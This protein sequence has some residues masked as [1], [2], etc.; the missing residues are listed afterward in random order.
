MKKILVWI[1]LLAVLL[2]TPVFAETAG[3]TEN[4]DFTEISDKISYSEKYH[5]FVNNLTAFSPSRADGV[6]DM[7]NNAID[8]LETPVPVYLYFV[9]SSRSHPMQAQ[10][11]EDSPFYLHLCERLHTTANDHLKYTTFGEFC[12]Y[13]YATDHHWNHRGAYQGY[14]DIIRMILGE[15]EKVLVPAEEVTLPV[16]YNGALAKAAGKAASTE[17]FSLYRYNRLRTYICHIN[18]KRHRYDNIKSY[19][20]GRYSTEEFAN[21]YQLCY[22][23][24]YAKL[25]FET[26]QAGKPNLLVFTNSIG[27]G[28]KYLLP[29]HFNRIVC[30]DLRSYLRDMGEPLSLQK[31]VSEYRIGQILILG[32]SQFFIDAKDLVP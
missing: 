3:D 32:E 20:S 21:H 29:S 12:N 26:G 11:D 2:W 25:V 13:F 5:R 10:F 16:I 30:I 23:G 1:L 17:Q 7:F 9:E 22:G 6:I 24:N 28:V 31:T 27:A 18:G 4:L 14:V 19:L 8:A 15:K